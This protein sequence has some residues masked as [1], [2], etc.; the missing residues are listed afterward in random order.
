VRV[1][2]NRIVLILV[3]A[4]VLAI[5]LGWMLDAADLTSRETAIGA[6]LT[7]WLAALASTVAQQQVTSW[8]DRRA[9]WRE[10]AANGI[11]LL[12]GRLPLVSKLIDPVEIGA[13][14]AAERP[15][16]EGHPADRVPAYVRRDVDGA[17]REALSESGFTLLVGDATAGKTRTAY[18]AMRAVLPGHVFIAPSSADGV[19]AAVVQARDRDNCVLWLDD[20]QAFLSP[21]GGI[22]RKDIAELLAGTGHRRVVLA[23]MRAID[24]SSLT[25][26][27]PGAA[28]GGVAD[29]QFIRIGQSVLDQVRHRFFVERLFSVDE[30]ARARELAS[31]DPRLADAVSHA[32]HNGIGEY[33][34]W[35]P[36]LY[37]QW[38]DAWARGGHP[39]AAALIAAAVDC[40]HAGFTSPLPRRLLDALHDSYLEM[41]GGDD[42]NPEDPGIAWRWAQ[43]PRESGSAPLRRAGADHCDVFDY[44]VDESRRRGGGVAPEATARAGLDHASPGDAGSIAGTAW[45]QRRHDLA[46]AALRR[47]YA[48]VSQE[49]TADIPVVLA[50]RNNLAIMLQVRRRLAEAEAEYRAI[51]ADPRAGLLDL[52][53]VRSN[54]AAVLQEQY[55][56]PEAEAEYRAVFAAL[57]A[58]P[59]PATRLDVLK[60]RN[61]FAALLAGTD[62]LDEA[63]AEFGAVLEVR[64]RELGPD[65]PITKKS[66]DNLAAVR[67]KL[68]D[69][70]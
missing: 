41:R 1:K 40:R 30:Q 16:A 23:T 51:L 70:R 29:G 56:L 22:T 2:R 10:A 39:R 4:C 17:L 48:A 14:P 26:G 54:L 9:V 21:S 63:E 59:R 43:S 52:L 19:A 6:G 64:A 37:N 27:G 67:H 57:A 58:Q 5:A 20:L 8:L 34:A 49:A 31:S 3:V 66:R 7:A 35:G 42:L 13:H 61:N 46:E 47:Q 68:R 36:Q 32:G 50:I 60:L 12:D 28:A 38:E 24:E 45:R 53:Q 33:L 25:G 18:E 44:L 62:R 15:A 69:E 11:Y 65:H 55:R